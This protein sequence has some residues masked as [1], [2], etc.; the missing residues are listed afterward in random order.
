MIVVWYLSRQI[1]L[2]PIPLNLIVWP[3]RRWCS[4]LMSFLIRHQ[5]L[6]VHTE[7]RGFVWILGLLKYSAVNVRL[8]VLPRFE[9]F[10][11][12]W[13]WDAVYPVCSVCDAF[14]FCTY[15]GVCVL[16]QTLSNPIDLDS[17]TDTCGSDAGDDLQSSQFVDDLII[18]PPMSRVDDETD[19]DAPAVFKRNL[20][21]DFDRVSKGR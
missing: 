12:W 10:V 5:F 7:S 14:F 19:S 15:I 16:S 20:S 6:M 13:C 21:K 2:D 11:V 18:T 8:I 3:V 17:D 4:L 9:Q 1:I